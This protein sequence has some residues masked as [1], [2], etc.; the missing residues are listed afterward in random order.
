MT[1]SDSPSARVLSRPLKPDE[2][3]RFV[4]LSKRTLERMRATECG[5]RFFRFGR[6]VRYAIAD[7]EHWMG[8]RA[9]DRP[10]RRR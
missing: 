10:G 3:A 4:G 8:E 2:A 9:V 1:M 5:P 7:L 6:A